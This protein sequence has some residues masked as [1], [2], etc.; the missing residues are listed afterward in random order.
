MFNIM[1]SLGREASLSGVG[2]DVCIYLVVIYDH[3]NKR[4]VSFVGVHPHN[5]T[6]RKRYS[7]TIQRRRGKI[8]VIILKKNNNN[9]NNNN[10]Y[11]YL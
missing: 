10:N 9:N 4:L 6:G 7:Y 1:T 5:N 8:I 11:N 2:I 3:I